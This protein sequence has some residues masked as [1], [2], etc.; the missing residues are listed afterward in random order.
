M[1][2]YRI[3]YKKSDKKYYCQKLV[4]YNSWFGLG[5]EKQKYIYS[6]RWYEGS[7]NPPT[8]DTFDPYFFNDIESAK[9]HLKDIMEMDKLKD[10]EIIYEE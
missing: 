7:F 8:S 10:I 4:K 3:I 6:C 2:K 5:K 9:E 1:K